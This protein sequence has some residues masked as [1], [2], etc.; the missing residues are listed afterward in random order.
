[1]DKLTGIIGPRIEEITLARIAAAKAAGKD[2][3]IVEAAVLGKAKEVCEAC[4]LIILVQSVDDQLRRQRVMTRSGYPLEKILNAERLQ[5]DSLKALA[6]HPK[7]VVVT[8]D[9]GL[10]ELE[11]SLRT[12]L[13]AQKADGGAGL[14]LP[15]E[16]IHLCVHPGYSFSN[17]RMSEPVSRKTFQ[18]WEK[19][20]REALED[21]RTVLVVFAPERPGVNVPMYEDFIDNLRGAG[22]DRIYEINRFEE[23]PYL[24]KPDCHRLLNPRRQYIAVKDKESVRVFAWGEYFGACV[25]S[26]AEEFRRRNKLEPEQVKV[27]VDLCTDCEG[28]SACMLEAGDM[29]FREQESRFRLIT[30][31]EYPHVKE[32]LR[33]QWKRLTRREKL[34]RSKPRKKA[35]AQSKPPEIN[36]E[37]PVFS[38]PP[39]PKIT[40]VRGNPEIDSLV[41]GMDG[42]ASNSSRIDSQALS[43]SS[44][45]AS[46]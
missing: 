5:K 35:Q 6:M 12:C 23:I 22:S 10:A 21:P 17:L 39:A 40:P 9:A 45:L 7:T 41:R 8:N 38:E 18:Q 37:K 26:L 43:L 27:I 2:A 28:H 25:H 42:T 11:D 44:V 30:T 36:E 20:A 14:T 29:A 4:E 15:A 33:V 13:A 34:A 24:I 3:V 16:T 32:F 46:I 1:M 31:I 19:A